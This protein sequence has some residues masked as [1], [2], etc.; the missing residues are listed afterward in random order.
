[1]EF[2]INSY[3]PYLANKMMNV[4]QMTICWHVDDLKVSHKDENA[5]TALAEKLAE[6]YGPKTT[7]SCGKAH[8][9]LGMDIDWASVTGTMIVSMIKY[10]HEVIE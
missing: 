1:M 9:Y 10:M 3:D 4:H 6:L 2:Q 8:K 7:V 5:V